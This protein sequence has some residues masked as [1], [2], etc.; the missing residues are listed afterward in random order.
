MPVKIL[1]DSDLSKPVKVDYHEAKEQVERELEQRRQESERALLAEIAL[2][3]RK[4]E[5]EERKRL[6]EAEKAALNLEDKSKADLANDGSLE[7]KSILIG[8]FYPI[9]F[10]DTME[11]EFKR[12]D[13][14][15]KIVND[16]REFLQIIKG[17]MSAYDQI[18]VIST[19]STRLSSQEQEEF[20]AKTLEFFNKGRSL[21]IWGDN[22]PYYL[23]ANLL[24][25]R[26][27]LN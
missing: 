24:L 27:P 12:V 26:L 9:K 11:V 8:C 17:N 15:Y 25:K 4:F 13:V 1:T 18:W 20:V 2:A 5:E 14:D 23:H 21:M 22:D 6:E 3:E 16:E 7:G 10:T 19:N